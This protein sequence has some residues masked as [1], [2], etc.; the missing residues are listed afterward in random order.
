MVGCDKR[1]IALGSL[2]EYLHGIES[3][4]T[5][6]L[7]CTEN[8]RGVYS[9][10]SSSEAY[11]RA[12]Q[13]VNESQALYLKLCSMFNLVRETPTIDKTIQEGYLYLQKQQER[14]YLLLESCGI[15]DPSFDV[16]N[17]NNNSSRRN[18]SCSGETQ[19]T[20][21][22]FKK[23][24]SRSSLDEWEA[25]TLEQIGLSETSLEALKALNVS[26][27]NSKAGLATPLYSRGTRTEPS[28]YSESC[29]YPSRLSETSREARIQD[30]EFEKLVAPFVRNSVSVTELSEKLQLL[31]EASAARNSKRFT[32]TQLAQIFHASSSKLKLYCLA[33][34]QLKYL[35]IEGDDLV[36]V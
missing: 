8:K 13:F 6:L 16:Y 7:S 1:S 2:Q 14:L 17:G 22:T 33:L 29:N 18:L 23:E 19:R 10:V 35:R 9:E 34:V 28:E 3:D 36:L 31:L 4:I 21:S 15:E 11:T 12:N 30:V 24:K 25:P 5:I 27:P 32:Q 26:S 20:F